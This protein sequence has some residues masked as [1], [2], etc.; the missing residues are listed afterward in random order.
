MFP[1]ALKKGTLRLL[2]K[3]TLSAQQH[4]KRALS[5]RDDKQKGT[6]LSDLW[7]AGRAHLS[8]VIRFNT[9]VILLCNLL[10]SFC[11][12][13]NFHISEILFYHRKIRKNFFPSLYFNTDFTSMLDKIRDIITSKIC[14]QCKLFA[15]LYY[16]VGHSIFTPFLINSSFGVILGISIEYYQ[17]LPLQLS[18][19]KQ[20]IK[21]IN[22]CGTFSG[23]HDHKFCQIFCC[24]FHTKNLVTS[25]FFVRF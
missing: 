12:F 11:S 6:F 2:K 5:A 9:V 15:H 23:R 18:D 25:L 1:P 22:N 20:R 10:F 8:T 19:N 7:H 4:V 13:L 24:R 17:Y 21:A 16:Q 14:F 3:G